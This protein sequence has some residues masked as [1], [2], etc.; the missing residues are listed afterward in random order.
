MRF[1]V[2]KVWMRKAEIEQW[3]A[4][5]TRTRPWRFARS[6]MRE[7]PRKSKSRISLVVVRGLRQ[8]LR[9][10][11]LGRR[12]VDYPNPKA[13]DMSSRGVVATLY[14]PQILNPAATI[15]VPICGIRYHTV[16]WLRRRFLHPTPRWEATRLNTFIALLESHKLQMTQS[17]P[18]AS[19]SCQLDHIVLVPQV[20][21]PITRHI[22]F[23]LRLPGLLEQCLPRT[24]WSPRPTF[25]FQL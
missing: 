25:R 13:A 3:R 6:W 23:L 20:R 9:L 5:Y 18:L 11:S 7:I 15:P 10:Y 19:P 17:T 16:S 24:R 4:S 8:S 12:S 22:L 1:V 21:H 14:A 2:Q